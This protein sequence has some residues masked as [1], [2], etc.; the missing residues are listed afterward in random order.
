LR[1]L[2]FWGLIAL[3]ACG[4]LVVF[5]DYFVDRPLARYAAGFHFYDG[6]LASGPVTSPILVGLAVATVLAGTVLLS[7]SFILPG[8]CAR[9]A[10]AA[11]LAGLAMSWGL[12]L[13]EFLL[14][15]LFARHLPF[16]YLYNGLYGFAWLTRA[17]DLESFPSGHAVQITSIASVLWEFYPRA[18]L[19]LAGAV[20]L[21]AAAL[22]LA[23]RHF[24]SDILAGS[25]IGAASGI[26]ML[27]LW[28]AHLD[29]G[30]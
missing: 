8:W 29:N 13:T 3:L 6:L 22:I 4:A 9:A 14:K 7:G 17:D 20:G 11:V 28:R 30:R 5:S 19:V 12:C 16:E 10:T 18:R 21:V 25:L 2:L 1:K 27:R 23:E 15:P 26:M 24:L